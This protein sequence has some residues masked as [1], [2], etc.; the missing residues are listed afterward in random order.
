MD[1]SGNYPT[2]EALRSHQGLWTSFGYSGFILKCDL[3]FQISWSSW[4]L[5]LMSTSV[6]FQ[7]TISKSLCYCLEVKYYLFTVFNSLDKI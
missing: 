7:T 5:T 4:D 6:A 1:S 3:V 2:P